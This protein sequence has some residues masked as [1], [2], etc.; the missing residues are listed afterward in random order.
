MPLIYVLV[1]I[2]QL[3]IVYQDIKFRAIHFALLIILF[4][5]GIT[6]LFLM[7]YPLLD[8]LWSLGYLII[9]LLATYAYLVIK[10]KKWINPFKTYLGIGDVLYFIALV[11]Y[12]SLINYVCFFISGL[13]FSILLFMIIKNWN[14]NFSTIP[15]AG[16]LSV[17]FILT[18]G[19]S[20]I[21]NI[22][23]FYNDYIAKWI[24]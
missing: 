5:L 22:D 8:T 14:K 16:F 12:F 4:A 23:F 11:P 2:T 10:H 24:H 21:L 15:L 1:L 19:A 9:C 17:F 20:Q 7:G 6:H 3:I 13:L 18:Y